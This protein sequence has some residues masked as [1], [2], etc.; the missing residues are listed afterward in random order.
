MPYDALVER[1]I[2]KPRSEIFAAL[3]DFGGVGKLVPDAVAECDCIGEG[4]GAQRTLKLADGG[5][6]VERLD[7]AHDDSVF[8][9]SVIEN[10]ALPV[11]HYCAVVTLEDTS[12]GATAVTWGS[13]W[14][15]VGVPDEEVA[16]AL[17]GL[18]NLLLDAIAAGPTDPA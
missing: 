3:Y 4:V 11:E 12:N 16:A 8:A 6:I 18:Y 7:V 9:Y 10:N 17:E 13:N 2:E 1:I 5:C 14:T 15:P